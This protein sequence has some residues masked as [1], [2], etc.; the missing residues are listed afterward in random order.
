MGTLEKVLTGEKQ[1]ETNWK[2]ITDTHP[3]TMEMLNV[4]IGEPEEN[5]EKL[6]DLVNKYQKCFAIDIN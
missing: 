1:E 2:S 4:N 5:R 3:I 6:L